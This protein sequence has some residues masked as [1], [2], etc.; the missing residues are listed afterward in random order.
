MRKRLLRFFP[1]RR[2][3]RLDA[4]LVRRTGHS[5]FSFLLAREHGLP[6]RRPLALTTTGRRSGR[7][8][9]IAISHGRTD[10]GAFTL[11][12][13]NGGSD[14]PPHWLLNLEADPRATVHVARRRLEVTAE[15][16]WGE[17][18]GELW[19]GIVERAPVYGR[20]QA[21]TTRDIP[22]VVLRPAA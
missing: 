22:V 5:P 4:F 16:L 17:A 21:G 15:I 18:K 9:T 11:V 12:A 10:D 3:Q 7:A 20:Y 8:H 13:S 6:Y 2:G 14:R 1:T 19:R